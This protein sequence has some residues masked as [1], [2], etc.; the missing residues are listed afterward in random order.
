VSNQKR[1][2]S[3]KSR[4]NSATKYTHTPKL[5]IDP[6]TKEH[7][8]LLRYVERQK[9]IVNVSKIRNQTKEWEMQTHKEENDKK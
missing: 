2:Q 1:S 8:I 6:E 5:A 7:E 4:Q 9:R 3:L